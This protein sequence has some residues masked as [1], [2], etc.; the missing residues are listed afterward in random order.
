MNYSARQKSWEKFGTGMY[1]YED[2]YEEVSDIKVTLN[3]NGVSLYAANNFTAVIQKYDIAKSKWLQVYRSRDKFDLVESLSLHNGAANFVSLAG[4]R[5]WNVSDPTNAAVDPEITKLVLKLRTMIGKPIECVTFVTNGAPFLEL[6]SLWILN[7]PEANRYTRTSS[8]KQGVY[9]Q[10]GYVDN[11]NFMNRLYTLM[12]ATGLNMIT[13]DMKDDTGN[14]RFTPH[15]EFLKQMGTS[16]FPVD[17]DKF[18]EEAKARGIYLVARIVLFKDMRMYN[19]DGGRFAV[20]DSVT[21]KPWRGMRV[22]DGVTNLMGEYWV[23][24]YAEEVWKYN[25]EVCKEL[26]QRGFDEIQFDYIRF[27]TDG[28]NLCGRNSHT[29]IPVWTRKA[30]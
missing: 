15:S 28:L 19:Y 23:D 20:K 5:D 17:I 22:Q 24:P 8:G 10:A 3:E 27:P 12:S 14:L 21:G 26:L 30:R 7:P 13:I 6:S 9:L 29:G 25:V 1:E 11:P 18:I 16:H 2:V 4:V